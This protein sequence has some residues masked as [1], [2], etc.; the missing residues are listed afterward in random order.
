MIWLLVF[1]LLLVS[2]MFSGIE[3]GMLSVNRVR[4]Q[5]RLKSGEK[6][7]IKLDRLL[8][9]PQRML[10]T[11]LLVTNLM[12]ICALIL[13]THDLVRRL[14]PWGYLASFLVFLPIYLL[15]LELLP[16]SMFRRFPYR[17]LA[18]LAEVLRLTDLILSPVLGIGSILARFLVHRNERENGKKKLFAGR[19]EFKHL[20]I[21][22]EKVGTLGRVEREMIHNVVDFGA[23]KAGDVMTPIDQA[24]V[25]KTGSRVDEAARVSQ[26]RRTDLLP[27]LND[28]GEIVGVISVYEALLDGHAQVGASQ[29]RVFT[30]P[31][32]EPAY[33]VIRKLRAARMGLAGVLD[34]NGKP[35]GIVRSED[36]IR[37]VVTTAT[38]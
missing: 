4:L 27:V 33:S 35:V 22:S 23:V 18:F 20:T 24:A 10:G 13:A 28:S 17:A 12:N 15:G 25:I 37:R 2:F 26:Q 21:E 16:K 7:A 38:A 29:R 19:E 14:G 5:H 8:T 6:A 32:H 3:A 11:V 34:S 1:T 9:H 30:V 31:A 36:L